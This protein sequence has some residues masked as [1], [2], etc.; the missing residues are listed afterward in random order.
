MPENHLDLSL[1]LHFGEFLH[2]LLC[3]AQVELVGYARAV[4][5]GQALQA[6][7]EQGLI[8]EVPL[9]VGLVTRAQEVL[10]HKHVSGRVIRVGRV[11]N[12][13]Y[14]ESQNIYKEALIRKHGFGVYIYFTCAVI[15][16]EGLKLRQDLA[17]H[18]VLPHVD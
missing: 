17:Q 5:L 3:A 10:Q 11:D 13:W 15:L 7:L 1:F 8:L 14:R 9:L 18:G 2:D 12:L 16:Y 4:Q 6:G